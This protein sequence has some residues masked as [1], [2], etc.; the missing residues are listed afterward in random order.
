MLNGGIKMP[1][2]QIKQYERLTDAELDIM[3]VLW[4]NGEGLRAG[5][6]VKLL[7][8]TRSWK[9]QT[10]HVLLNRLEEKGFVSA[11]RSGYFH[12]YNSAITE[13]EYF[14]SESDAFLRRL[15]GSVKATVA[16]LIDAGD[17]SDTELSELEALIRS[18]LGKKGE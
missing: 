6:I 5:Q 4:Q 9:T 15:G 16:S 8:E 10:A 14:A 7:S 13:K 18:R 11:D 17:I 2:T 3:R 12:T 1:N